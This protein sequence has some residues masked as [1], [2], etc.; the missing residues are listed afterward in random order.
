[1][2]SCM[3]QLCLEYKLHEVWNSIDNVLG[4]KDWGL[5]GIRRSLRLQCHSLMLHCRSLLYCC[6]QRLHS[7]LG[8]RFR[9]TDCNL[10]EVARFCSDFFSLKKNTTVDI[11]KAT[12]KSINHVII[13]NRR[14]IKIDYNY[15]FKSHFFYFIYSS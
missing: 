5:W 2:L 6:F 9:E 11:F 10:L 3:I 15:H 13:V 4:K 1:M 8:L 7:W 12:I 14:V